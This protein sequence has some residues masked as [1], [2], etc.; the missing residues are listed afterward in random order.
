LEEA[1]DEFPEQLVSDIC[2]WCAIVLG[3]DFREGA[4]LAIARTFSTTWGDYDTAFTIR[5]LADFVVTET[6]VAASAL[7][8]SQL[9]AMSGEVRAL[10]VF[11]AQSSIVTQA[12]LRGV[13]N[14]VIFLERAFENSYGLLSAFPPSQRAATAAEIVS[15]TLCDLFFQIEEDSSTAD[16][17]RRANT[18][19]LS[20]YITDYLLFLSELLED[21]ISPL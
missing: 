10:T 14:F 6:L 2:R 11:V 16:H 12:D 3:H 8:R 15:F 21:K 1:V 17:C 5:V 4:E 19:P 20:E 18:A 7:L 13:S 9:E